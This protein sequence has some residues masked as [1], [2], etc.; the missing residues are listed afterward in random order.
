MLNRL[1]GVT[2][3]FAE[4]RNHRGIGKVERLIG[5][6]QTIFNLY[7][8][9]SGN[10]LI[11][12]DRS[13]YSKRQV[14]ERVKAVLPFIQQSLNRRKPRFTQYSPN[15]MMFGSELK[16]YA[17]IKTMIQALETE[18]ND[19]NI[20][21][22]DFV[23]I[24]KLLSDLQT[25]QSSYE[26]DWKKYTHFSKKQFDTQHNIKADNLKVILDTFHVGDK[27]LHYVGDRQVASRKW[28]QR[29]SGPWKIASIDNNTAAI[30]IMDEETANSKFVSVD[31]IK[32]WNNGADTISLSDFDELEIHHN[33]IKKEFKTTYK[34]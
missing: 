34:L 11:P 18:R 33:Q 9:Q 5:Y 14:W 7:N 19:K 6:I 12:S 26:S 27:V 25:I 8:V 30:E 15:M 4:A 21:R 1:I 32:P 2:H 13:D 22:T 16:D 31:R 29:W 10:K 23:Y 24:K 3:N 17:N 20:I 28:R